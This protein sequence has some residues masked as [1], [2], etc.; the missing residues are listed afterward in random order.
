METLPALSHEVWER[1]PP[2]AHASLRTLEARVAT[3]EGMMQ[4]LHAQLPQ[5]SRHSSR[6]PVSDP[7]PSTT[8]LVLWYTCGYENTSCTTSYLTFRTLFRTSEAI[9]E[10]PLVE[11]GAGAVY[12]LFHAL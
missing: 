1:I 10:E 6:S 8:S 2:D 4:A 11:G 5:T 3:F 12:R 9:F 7:P